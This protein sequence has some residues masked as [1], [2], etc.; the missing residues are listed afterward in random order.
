MKYTNEELAESKE[1]CEDLQDI[2]T[3]EVGRDIEAQEKNRSPFSRHLPTSSKGL[4]LWLEN[5]KINRKLQILSVIAE[6]PEA[7]L[8]DALN[9]AQEN[10]KIRED[11]AKEQSHMSGFFDGYKWCGK[12]FKE[13]LDEISGL[14][15]WAQDNPNAQALKEEDRKAGKD[16]KTRDEYE[17]VVEEKEAKRLVD[18]EKRVAREK[19]LGIVH[20]TSFVFTSEQLDTLEA[21]V[22]DGKSI[23]QARKELE[24]EF[25]EM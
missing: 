18:I 2:L 17:E 23:E 4:T 15:L 12:L 16:L 6:T 8:L 13:C 19:A 22:A 24:K 20:D 9:E 5:E 11:L 1:K 3:E 10:M 14:N 7:D 25:E 21:K